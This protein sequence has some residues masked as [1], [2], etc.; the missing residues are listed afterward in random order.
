MIW[1][2]QT[3]QRKTIKS[4]EDN[5]LARVNVS[6]VGLETTTWGN[7]SKVYLEYP[8]LCKIFLRALPIVGLGE[9]SHGVE[10]ICSCSI[11]HEDLFTKFVKIYQRFFGFLG[12]DKAHGN[13]QSRTRTE[14]T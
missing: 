2:E 6:Y 14:K 10:A 9:F 13:V 11:P 1:Q 5:H 12:I 8:V 4:E 7:A 3:T